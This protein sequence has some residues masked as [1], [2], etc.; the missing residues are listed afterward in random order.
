MATTKAAAN[1]IIEIFDLKF[2]T[3]KTTVFL[4]PMIYIVVSIHSTRT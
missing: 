2:Y 4:K 3:N 1:G